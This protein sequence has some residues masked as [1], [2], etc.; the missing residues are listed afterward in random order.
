ML[1]ACTTGVTSVAGVD[2]IAQDD[3]SIGVRRSRA[4]NGIDV[5]QQV[6]ALEAALANTTKMVSGISADQWDNST[7]CA[8]WNVREL[9]QHTVGVMANFSGGA[10]NTGPVGDPSEFDLGDDPAATC[11]SVASDCVANWGARGELESNISLGD[12]EFPGMVGI[13]INTLDAYVHG[14]DIAQATGQDAALDAALCT[15][16]LGFSHQAIPTSPR[17]GDNFHAVVSTGGDSSVQNQLLGSLGR[18]P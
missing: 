17:E 10:A 6:A 7:P 12:K 9:V 18:Q 16:L 1:P 14:W 4:G 5:E 11:A 3:S 2:F 15:G 13:S 8:K